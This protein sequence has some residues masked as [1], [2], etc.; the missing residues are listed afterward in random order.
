MAKS[1]L[2]IC[3]RAPWSGPAAR[4]ALDVALAG[5][6]F[7]LPIALLFLDDGVFQLQAGQQPAAVQQKD[8]TANLQALPLFG[9]EALYVARADLD[10]RGLG[11]EHLSLPVT[12]V[13]DADLAA[14]LNRHDLVIT[15]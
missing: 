10:R 5:G 13:E 7:D 8:L 1:L 3:R 4:E 6:A 2:L 12:P 15:L 14:L 9:V 11:T